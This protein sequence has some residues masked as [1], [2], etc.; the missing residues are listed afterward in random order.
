MSNTMHVW[1]VD[2]DKLI[3]NDITFSRHS[4]S[5]LNSEPIRKIM[6]F[7][8]KNGTNR[9]S[10]YFPREID[11]FEN[12]GKRYLNILKHVTNYGWCPGTI[13]HPCDALD[14]HKV[15]FRFLDERER[16]RV[17]TYLGVDFS[18]Y[19]PKPCQLEVFMDVHG[20]HELRVLDS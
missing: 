10:I 13:N 18:M 7:L 17:S 4:L 15:R 16:D 19:I 6:E 14:S 3:I 20:I 11:P 8:E 2:D 9:C 5:L 1:D 12:S